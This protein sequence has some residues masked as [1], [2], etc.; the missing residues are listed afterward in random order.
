[1]EVK[2]EKKNNFDYDAYEDYILNFLR[3][4]RR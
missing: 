4:K 2:V 1:M 3:R